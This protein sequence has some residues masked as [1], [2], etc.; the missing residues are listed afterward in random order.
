[1]SQPIVVFPSI[2]DAW[3]MHLR[4]AFADLDESAEVHDRIPAER[5]T[6]F[7]TLVRGGGPRHDIVTDNPTV[8]VEAWAEDDE[9]AHDLAQL[10]RALLFATAGSVVQGVTVYRV[11]EFAGPANLP[12]PESSQS[13]FVFTLSPRVRGTELT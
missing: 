11:D 1:M 12:D 9:T 5:P 10:A 6:S 8:L 2:T 7:V 4:Q 13:R 3:V